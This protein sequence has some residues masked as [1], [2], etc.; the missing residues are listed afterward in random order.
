MNGAARM[1]EDAPAP[2]KGSSD[3]GGSEDGRGLRPGQHRFGVTGFQHAGP[4]SKTTYS[5]V[6]PL[7]RLGVRGKV[8]SDPG[9][10]RPPVAAARACL[11]PEMQPTNQSLPTTYC[12]WEHRA[13]WG[14]GGF[15]RLPHDRAC[16][17]SVGCRSERAPLQA[18]CRKQTQP[19]SS[20]R[21]SMPRTATSRCACLA[22][23]SSE[24][25]ARGL[26]TL[27]SAQS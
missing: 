5:F 10:A 16:C 25:A 18:T 13:G 21:G 2:P 1:G 11:L 12:Q 8:R 14:P 6:D 20:Q 9:G 27:P 24:W 23:A 15:L 26:C 17:V 22:A 19:R 4:V 7:I 3:E